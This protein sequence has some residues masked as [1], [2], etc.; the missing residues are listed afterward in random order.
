MGNPDPR[1]HYAAMEAG[2][3]GR[4][5]RDWPQS[6]PIGARLRSGPPAPMPGRR[7]EQVPARA[8]LSSRPHFVGR[9]E[10]R[11]GGRSIDRAPSGSLIVNIRQGAAYGPRGRHVGVVRGRPR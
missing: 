7:V 11:P 9:T 3:V 5:G 2:R 4:S 10:G 6:S 8:P 1:A